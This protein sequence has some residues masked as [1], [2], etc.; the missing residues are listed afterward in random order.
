M[1]KQTFL[2]GAHVRRR[3]HQ[4]GICAERGDAAGLFDGLGRVRQTGAGEHWYATG[5]QFHRG[6]QD[7]V[8]FDVVKRRGFAGGTGDDQRLRAAI[9]LRL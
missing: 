3:H 2:R 8:V 9:E 1:R 4:R 5:D 6:T 7:R